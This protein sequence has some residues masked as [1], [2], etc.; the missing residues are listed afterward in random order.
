MRRAQQQ[1]ARTLQQGLEAEATKERAQHCRVRN[2]RE[3]RREQ[4]QA[5]SAY[6]A[7]VQAIRQ[8]A[9]VAAA[10]DASRRVQLAGSVREFEGTQ[11]A[12][13][14]TQRYMPSHSAASTMQERLAALGAGTAQL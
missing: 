11:R 14:A 12:K 10:Q 3:R 1:Q 6:D 8:E 13:H 4:R 7:K 5:L 2:A 9:A